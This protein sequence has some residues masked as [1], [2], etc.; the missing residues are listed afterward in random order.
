MNRFLIALVF[1]PAATAACGNDRA[2]PASANRD[3]T[4][5]APDIQVC[6]DC[7]ACEEAIPVKSANH[8]EGPIQ[9]PDPPPSSGDHNPCWAIWGIH[10]DAVPAERW[11]HNLE[12]G[13]IVFLYNCPDGCGSDATAIAQLTDLVGRRQLALITPYSEMSQ[14]FAVVSWGHRLV[15]A[16]V[17]PQAAAAFYAVHVGRGPEAITDNPDPSCDP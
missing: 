8:V 1:L 14:K 2:A 3:L 4:S 11:V 5:T 17:D 10:T 16:C 13:G 9:Y 15:S 6:D 7:G 12:H